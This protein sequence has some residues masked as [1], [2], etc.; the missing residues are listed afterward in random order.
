[1]DK[2]PPYWKERIPSM[3]RRAL[4]HDYTGCCDY[5]ITLL[6]AEGIPA[7]SSV[8]GTAA[9]PELRLTAVGAAIA[10]A[11]AG[12]PV[13]MPAISIA[14]SVIMPDHVHFLICVRRRTGKNLSYYVN[15]IMGR[16]TAAWRVAEPASP[17][18]FAKGFNDRV[19]F[20]C[21]QREATINYIADNP[22]RLLLRRLHPDL[23]G[24]GL[25][26]RIAGRDYKAFGNIFLLRAPQRC[27]VAVHRR[28]SAS[29]LTALRDLWRRVASNGGVLVS[30]FISPAEKEVRAEGLALGASVVQIVHEGISERFKPS[31][32]DFELC[33]QGRLLLIA[34][35]V[36]DTRSTPLSRAHC[37]AMNELAE[38]ICAPGAVTMSVRRRGAP[39]CELSEHLSEK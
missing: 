34:P 7:F 26:V 1:M 18:L 9:A 14:A 24:K 39:S 38:L 4:W 22:R 13:L 21:A 12:A 2:L 6:K 17:G 37:L 29:E 8:A 10:E 25:D 16:C 20:D 31:G 15:R 5:H 27:A 33:V 36:Y 23:F 3:H 28:Y 30:P 32:A 19:I 11:L 35:P